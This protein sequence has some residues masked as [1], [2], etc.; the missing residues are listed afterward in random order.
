M[1]EQE[2]DIF[3]ELDA[4]K[5]GRPE[6]ER[7]PIKVIAK[8]ARVLRTEPFGMIGLSLAEEL[9]GTFNVIVHLAYQMTMS[10]GKPVPATAKRTGCSDKRTRH[11]ALQLLEDLGRAEIEWRGQGAAPLV[12]RFDST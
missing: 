9:G 5:V 12:K 2:R 7:A 4:L 8:P 6:V 10:G 1:S 11:R 3:D